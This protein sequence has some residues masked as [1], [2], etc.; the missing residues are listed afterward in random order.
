LFTKWTRPEKPSP[1]NS[2]LIE[3][4][5]S[6]IKLDGQPQNAHPAFFG[7][8]DLLMA[9]V[10]KTGSVMKYQD[11]F[12]GTGFLPNRT[13]LWNIFISADSADAA[14]KALEGLG[15]AIRRGRVSVQVIENDFWF[16]L[17]KLHLPSPE[18][19]EHLNRKI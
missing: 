3:N 18:W 14:I 19:L 4:P 11:E 15:K 12:T 17:D 7:L 16:E 9:Q 2:K 13:F 8:N 5:Y 1:D 6:F 10:P